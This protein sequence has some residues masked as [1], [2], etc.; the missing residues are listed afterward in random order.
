MNRLKGRDKENIKLYFELYDDKCYPQQEIDTRIVIS[1]RY[2]TKMN[3]KNYTKEK[4]NTRK[5]KWFIKESMRF[6][7]T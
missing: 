2:I 7:L 3:R 6:I 4:E 1:R 5:S